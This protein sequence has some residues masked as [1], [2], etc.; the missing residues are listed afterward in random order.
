MDRFRRNPAC[1]PCR[2]DDGIDMASRIDVIIDDLVE[3]LD[4]AALTHTL[5]AALWEMAKRDNT[6]PRRLIEEMFKLSPS[7]EEYRRLREML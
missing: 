5:V 6:T 1:R 3:D 7:D 4:D 2:H